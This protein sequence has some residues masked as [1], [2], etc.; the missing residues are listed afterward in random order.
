MFLFQSRRVTSGWTTTRTP[1]SGSAAPT[2]PSP[3]SPAPSSWTTLSIW[4]GRAGSP[5]I[6]RSS[7]R[8]SWPPRRRWCRWAP[9]KPPSGKS[10]VANWV[11]IVRLA[12]RCFPYW[13]PPFKGTVSWHR[14]RQCWRKFTDVPS[15]VLSLTY[16]LGKTFFISNL[17]M[18]PPLNFFGGV[19]KIQVY[20][21]MK[22]KIQFSHCNY[23]QYMKPVSD[24][25]I[26]KNKAGF[27][28]KIKNLSS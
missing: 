2:P 21:K 17:F 5:T 1:G 3:P 19:S 28:C 14:F 20:G 23:L 4:R 8:G 22:W 7:S 18:W 16:F 6:R 27:T 25:V 12:N 15:N 24:R 11:K 10:G 26:S 9:Q 13:F